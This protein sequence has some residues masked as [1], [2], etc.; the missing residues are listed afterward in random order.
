[1][2][3]TESTCGAVTGALMVIGLRHGRI[4][5]ED[6]ASKEKVRKLSMEFTKKFRKRHRSISC[7]KLLGCSI[8]SKKGKKE[9][10]IAGAFDNCPEYVNT[11]AEILE[12]MQ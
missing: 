10:E 8:G 5:P 6:E 4:S 1:M 11:A 2:G 3:V 9:A 7:R 12:E